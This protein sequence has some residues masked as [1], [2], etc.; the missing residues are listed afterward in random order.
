MLEGVGN[1]L[2]KLSVIL[3]FEVNETLEN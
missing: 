2:L 1:G 3:D